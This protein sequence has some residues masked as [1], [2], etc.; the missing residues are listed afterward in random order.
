MATIA[1]LAMTIGS[2]VIKLK[3]EMTRPK[4]LP[5]MT[6]TDNLLKAQFM[7]SLLRRQKEKVILKLPQ[8]NR[9]IKIE[10]DKRPWLSSREAFTFDRT[11]IESRNFDSRPKAK[12]CSQVN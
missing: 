2:M 8:N 12:S 4:I 3:L 11:A 1:N 6:M 10:C 7:K 5:E 9:K